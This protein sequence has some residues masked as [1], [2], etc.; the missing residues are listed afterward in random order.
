M[1]K[2]K[3][4]TTKSIRRL[5][6]NESIDVENATV[7][8][9]HNWEYYVGCSL[10]IGVSRYVYV[11]KRANGRDLTAYTPAEARRLAEGK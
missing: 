3:T 5:R 8:K 4:E 2:T 10:G 7:M 9:V 6:L 1:T 11:I